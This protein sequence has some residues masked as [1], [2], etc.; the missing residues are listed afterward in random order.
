MDSDEVLAQLDDKV[1]LDLI[2]AGSC[3]AWLHMY[4]RKADSLRT[5]IVYRVESGTLADIEDILQKVFVTLWRNGHRYKKFTKSDFA[6]QKIANKILVLSSSNIRLAETE[7]KNPSRLKLTQD[8]IGIG[9]HNDEI[10]KLSL[11]YRLSHQQI[12][13]RL[14]LPLGTVK[15]RLNESKKKL[16]NFNQIIDSIFRNGHSK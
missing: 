15:W 12:A 14:Q 16:R 2:F 9:L 4:W 8:V 13:E 6:L 10:L 11:F 3:N 5:H 1:L 7:S